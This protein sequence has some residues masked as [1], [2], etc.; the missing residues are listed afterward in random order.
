[1]RHIDTAALWIQDQQ[2]RRIL[3]LDKI[4]GTKNEADMMT[5]NLDF[6]RVDMYLDTTNLNF[7]EGRACNAVQQHLADDHDPSNNNDH[8]IRRRATQQH[9][10]MGLPKP[11]RSLEETPQW[12]QTR[13]LYPHALFAW[14]EP[15]CANRTVQAHQGRV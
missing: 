6:I 7:T 15:G 12:L 5:K 9:D 2:A 10:S 11:R 13:S 4:P 1:M 14:S 3:P 8:D